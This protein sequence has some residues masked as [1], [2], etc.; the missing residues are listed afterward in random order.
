AAESMR[1]VNERLTA[2]VRQRTAER[3]RL[4]SLFQ[5]APG[6]ICVLRGPAHVFELVN[7]AYLR[8]VG[9]RS[10]L[11]LCAR[12]AIPEAEGQGFFEKLDQVYQ[13]GEPYMGRHSTL[14]L[15]R[16]AECDLQDVCLHSVYQPIFELGGTVSGIFVEGNDVTEQTH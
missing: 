4:Q 10:L 14:P 8:L 12:E 13:S 16:G 6:F 7:E 9:Q 3:D 1:S 2:E 11:G 15:H 5:Q